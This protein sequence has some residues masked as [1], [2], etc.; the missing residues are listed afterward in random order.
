M[1]VRFAKKVITMNEL[2]A[3]GLDK[4]TIEKWYGSTGWEFIPKERDNMSKSTKI[5]RFDL[6]GAK[7]FNEEDSEFVWKLLKNPLN[8]MFNVGE[9]PV[10]WMLHRIDRAEVAVEWVLKN[11]SE[12]LGEKKLD[13]KLVKGLQYLCSGSTSCEFSVDWYEEH[14]DAV[15]FL[16]AD[17]FIVSGS[18]AEKNGICKSEHDVE[19]QFCMTMLENGNL[20]LWLCKPT[21]YY[22]LLGKKYINWLSAV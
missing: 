6:F 16:L 12:V 4:Y 18:F 20:K 19:L 13:G 9:T 3:H 7:D 1:S 11:V 22:S 10:I 2:L 15:D 17:N 5:Y 21:F 14:S 8:C